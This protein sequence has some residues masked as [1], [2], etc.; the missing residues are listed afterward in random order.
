MSDLR[1]CCQ[2]ALLD[3]YPRCSARVQGS[4]IASAP[5]TRVSSY[6][7]CCVPRDNINARHFTIHVRE[8][9]PGLWI[10]TDGYV[11][12]N[13]AG[14]WATDPSG[15]HNRHDEATA[16]RL[17]EAAAPHVTV[18]GHTVADALAQTESPDA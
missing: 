18:N 5:V 6:E 14:E 3:H 16:L 9:R 8:V 4:E 7:V 12:L 15:L 1:P 2:Q 10:A 13:E 17:A 11:C